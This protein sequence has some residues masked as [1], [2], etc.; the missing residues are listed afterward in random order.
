MDKVILVQEGDTTYT[1]T[2]SEEVGVV[3][4]HMLNPDMSLDFHTRH[5]FKDAMKFFET[6][7]LEGHRIKVVD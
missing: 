3:C 5:Y 2:P 6:F 1:F 7:V 4:I